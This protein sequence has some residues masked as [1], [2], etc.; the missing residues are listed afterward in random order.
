MLIPLLLTLAQAVA[1]ATSA[2][3]DSFRFEYFRTR[4]RIEADG[5]ARRSVEIRV[6]LRTPQG[7]QEFGQVAVPYVKDYGDVVYTSVRVHKP[8]GTSR[9]VSDGMLED[10]NPFGINDASIPIDVRLKKLTIPRLEPGDTL[11]YVMTLTH[12][13]FV[14]GEAYGEMKFTPLPVDGPQTYELDIPAESRIRVSLRPD[15]G[16]T[17]E[18]I[19]SEPDRLVR[20]LTLEVP[21]LVVAA[22]GATEAQQL[23][24]QNPDVSYT[25]FPTWSAVGTW[26]WKMSQAAVGGDDEIKKE[27]ERLTQGKTTPAARVEALARFVTQTVRYLNV[28]FGMGRMRPREAGS[29]LSSRYGDCKDK[30]GLLMALGESQG[31]KIRPALIS[32]K[33]QDLRDDAPGPHQFDHVIAV[34]MLGPTEKDWVWFDVT[35][36]FTSPDLLFTP[37]RDK[38][39][40][41]IRENGEGVLVKT[42]AVPGFPRRKL[43]ELNGTLD[44]SGLLKGHVRIADGSDASGS[45]RAFFGSAPPEQR[46]ELIKQNSITFWK[47]AKTSNYTTSD[48]SDTS[49]PFVYEFDFESTVS[50]L[51]TEKEWEFWI[52]DFGGVLADPASVDATAK[53]PITFLASEIGYKGSIELPEGATARAPLSVSLTRP[54]ASSE[55]AYS[56][57]GR[58]VKVT[59]T[60]RLNAAGITPDEMAAYT[61][62]YKA[63]DTDRKQDFRVGPIRVS[64]VAA[65]VTLQKQGKAA[66]NQK[67][68]PRALDLLEKAAAADPKL[69]GIYEDIGLVHRET[70]D[71][72][73]AVAAYTKAIEA[74]PYSESA[75]AERAYSNFELRHPEDAEK[76][77][78][79]QIEAA[80]FKEWSYRRLAQYRR[81]QKRYKEAADLFAKSLAI[82][83]KPVADWM[84]LGW[85]HAEAGNAAE[86]RVAFAKA[87]QLGITTG[88]RTYVARGYALIGDLKPADALARK[89][90]P[91]LIKK[92]VE[93]TKENFHGQMYW[94]DRMVEAWEVIGT[95][96]FAE[97]DL[98]TAERYLKASWDAGLSPDAGFTYMRLLAKR[99]KPAEASAV[100]SAIVAMRPSIY[101]RSEMPAVLKALGSAA[102]GAKA[103]TESKRVRA[104]QIP[105]EKPPTVLSQNV[106]VLVQDGR[107]TAVKGFSKEMETV[108][109]PLL[110]ALVGQPA[111]WFD[112]DGKGVSIV[113]D[114]Y[115]NCGPRGC[116]WFARTEAPPRPEGMAGPAIDV[117]S[118]RISS[119]SPAV[120]TELTA[121]ATVKMKVTLAYS[122]DGPKEGQVAL[123]AVDDRLIQLVTPQ[124]RKTVKPGSGAVDF[125]F[126]IVVPA[127]SQ[128]IRIHTLVA[129]GVAPTKTHEQIEFKVR[130]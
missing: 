68:F 93:I 27:A 46:P 106:N 71:H 18:T 116:T 81:S 98:D 49:Q 42:P 97:G 39:A 130:K 105:V 127:E 28:S 5:T 108:M 103:S 128:A 43:F 41:L 96:A 73:K 90:L 24:L 115:I 54:F 100:L 82:D 52:P 19:P 47:D 129:V 9:A 78:L 92:A 32:A 63:A 53:R 74:D 59:R 109:A 79:K 61:A 64:G 80:P 57:E 4:D 38:R 125:A 21:P 33:R 34:A 102:V 87:E 15:L 76:D 75:Y 12:K 72:E 107:V 37:L 118:I 31:L 124:L 11:A 119:V 70:K 122:L 14:P 58:T 65:A 111:P 121:G 95:A 23:A 25:T 83:P 104:I 113:R 3:S 7:V 91:E 94:T 20:K 1:P 89:D 120:G 117:G 6:R 101:E 67:D 26:W 56:I 84:D 10:L 99:G 69:K 86:A 51:D 55:S 16:A 85:S 45:L 36:N 112:P 62:L 30:V 110:D 40:L 44:A 77:L 29:V 17:W 123:Y 22:T 35:N 13:P 126:E 2:A 60:V 8:D 50:G 48:P 114:G 66:W 88:R